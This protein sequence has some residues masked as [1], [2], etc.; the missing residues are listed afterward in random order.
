[1]VEIVT[2]LFV[3]ELSLFLF[4]D[5]FKYNT[6]YTPIFFLGAPFAVVLIFAVF[7]GPLF[8][9]LPV[10][11]DAVIV[12]CI[13]TF[14]FWFSGG[15]LTYATINN[16]LILPFANISACRSITTTIVVISWIF[17]FI[18]LGSFLNSFARHGTIGGEVFSADFASHGIAAHCLSLM[19]YNAAY[20]FAVEDGRKKQRHIIIII[21]F[22]F[23]LLYNVKG[24]II[25]TALVSLFAKFIMSQ[26]KLNLKKIVTIVLAGTIVFVLSYG[27]ALGTINYKFLIFHFLAYVFAGIVGLSEHLRQGLSVDF[28]FL[29]IMQPIRNIYNVLTGGDVANQISDFWVT[30][31]IFYAKQSNVKTFFG[32]IYIY[33]GMIKGLLITSFF[34]LSSYLFFIITIVKR[35]MHYLIVYLLIGSSLMLGWFDFYFNNLFYYEVV[36]YVFFVVFVSKSFSFIRLWANTK[37]LA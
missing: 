22:V 7:L 2:A 35:R 11:V 16:R 37:K 26:S 8:G 25:L 12:W 3:F 9:F 29:L 24:A 19:K 28:D 18:L 21:T 5:W 17:I 15:L 20:L 36:V 27:I 30:T 13:G 1:M 6:L 10:S 23:L 32:T 14:I 31:N 34:A 33:A 4:V